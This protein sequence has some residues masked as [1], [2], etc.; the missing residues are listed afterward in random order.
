MPYSLPHLGR[1]R[2]GFDSWRVTE[3][4]V[5]A[6]VAIITLVDTVKCQRAARFLLLRLDLAGAC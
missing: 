2:A 1:S 6:S 4:H 5:T 3:R